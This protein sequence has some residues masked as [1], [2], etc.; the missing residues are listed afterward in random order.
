MGHENRQTEQ[1][2][3]RKQRY[4]FSDTMHFTV[5]YL[6]HKNTQDGRGG[7]S[8]RDLLVSFPL[9]VYSS[10]F[11]GQIAFMLERNLEKTRTSLELN[12]AMSL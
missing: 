2:P 1:W 6:F 3:V 11:L 10:L 5:A 8:S 4:P 12:V 9:T 7:I